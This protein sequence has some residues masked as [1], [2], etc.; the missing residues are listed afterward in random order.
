[1]AACECL[2]DPGPADVTLTADVV[3]V[4][5]ATLD[6][7]ATRLEQLWH[8]L[9]RDERLRADR[10]HFERDRR[11]FIAG[12]GLLRTILGRYLRCEPARIPLGY[13][14]HG[15]PALSAMPAGGLTLQFNLSHSQNLVLYA[16]TCG[17]RI[18][19]DVEHIRPI[20]EA[21]H[22]ARTLFSAREYAML[23]SLPPDKRILGFFN[24]WTRKEAYI[25]AWGDGLAHPL[26]QFDV[27]LIPG[28]PAR[29]L[30]TRE[31]T[32]IA[33]HW[34]L[35]A[36]T[37]ASGYVAALAVEGSRWHLACWQWPDH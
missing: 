24:C 30:S 14:P 23:Q 17:R 8:T 25:K 16:L 2:W 33:A 36:L 29:L 3:H 32:R 7:P 6:Q 15:K 31:D 34:S 20:P 19:V 13:G 10:F 4:W 26:D 22:I 28:E 21:E 9:T 12:R 18:G 37:P 11:R 5:C 27:S 1:L 35:R